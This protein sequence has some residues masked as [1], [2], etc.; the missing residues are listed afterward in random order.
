[1][2]GALDPGLAGF[3]PPGRP[4][5]L[6]GVGRFPHGAGS[7]AGPSLLLGEAGL[8]R[9]AWRDQPSG[10]GTAAAPRG[11]WGVVP[12]RGSTGSSLVPGP[13]ET[14]AFPPPEMAPSAVI[15]P[16]KPT[17]IF[18]GARSEPQLLRP[19]DSQPCPFPLSTRKVQFSQARLT[20][21][22]NVPLFGIWLE[23]WARAT[24]STSQVA[25]TG[26]PRECCPPDPP[27]LRKRWSGARL[28]HPGKWEIRLSAHSSVVF[29]NK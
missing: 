26:A 23:L 28:P 4:S 9:Q 1:M 22:R 18:L 20:V 16:R 11:L 24:A 15:S 29:R 13:P 8:L 17:L 14:D 3:P 27:L 25:A 10:P 7:W 6:G 2:R 19:G 5:G 21:K 12:I